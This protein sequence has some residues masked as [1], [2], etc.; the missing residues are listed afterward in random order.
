MGDEAAGGSAGAESYTSRPHCNQRRPARRP[1]SVQR[2]LIFLIVASAI[3]G[4]SAGT[5]DRGVVLGRFIQVGGPGRIVEGRPVPNR[6]TPLPG[7]VVARS[8]AGNTF[9]V[10]VGKS[11]KFRMLLPPGTYRLTGYSPMYS[12]P[13]TGETAIKIRAGMHVTRINVVCTVT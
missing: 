4:C 8:K 6:P 11:G 3:A 5:S 10:T 13:C 9:T 7:Q 12:G 1:S 2:H